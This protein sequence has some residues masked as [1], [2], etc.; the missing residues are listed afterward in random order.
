MFICLGLVV[1]LGCGALYGCASPECAVRS[2]RAGEENGGAGS[3]GVGD[4]TDQE[5]V[6]RVER[7]GA[8]QGLLILKRCFPF[9][10]LKGIACCH[11]RGM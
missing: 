1:V 2:A 9:G 11:G 4:G 7:R 10:K 8:W 3:A 6:S 5:N